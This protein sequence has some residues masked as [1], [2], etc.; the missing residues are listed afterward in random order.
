M[1]SPASGSETFDWKAA[2]ARALGPCE[3]DIK[4]KLGT[5][6][7]EARKAAVRAGDAS[8]F[9]TVVE[10]HAGAMGDFCEKFLLTRLRFIQEHIIASVTPDS[11][12]ALVTPDSKPTLDPVCIKRGEIKILYDDRYAAQW[13][14]DR[15][16][17]GL[18]WHQATLGIVVGAC[19]Q[20]QLTDGKT[21]EKWDLPYVSQVR[22]AVGGESEVGMRLPSFAGTVF[23]W[24]MNY[25][26]KVEERRADVH[27]IKIT[28]ITCPEGTP[29]SEEVVAALTVPDSDKG[30]YE[31]SKGPHQSL[32]EVYD[33]I[34]NALCKQFFNPD[35]H[36]PSEPMRAMIKL[37]KQHGE[38]SAGALNSLAPNPP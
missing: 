7:N 2:M 9:C 14:N 15:K 1:S 20:S 36:T 5:I 21:L 28:L 25:T 34:A 22:K 29:R 13:A 4:K 11:E 31:L 32:N 10:Q 19:F 35:S 37:A 30:D 24:Q 3:A 27:E 17:E 18:D 33:P 16:H 38:N 6:A 23:L 8:N 26:G 12:P